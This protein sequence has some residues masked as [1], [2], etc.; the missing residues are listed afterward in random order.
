M[1]VANLGLAK[2]IALEFRRRGVELDDLIAE[3]TVGLIEAVDRFDGA[4]GVG[5]GV[6]ARVWIRA[7]CTRAVRAAHRPDVGGTDLDLDAFPAPE[8]AADPI[9]ETV[10]SAVEQLPADERVVTILAFGLHGADPVGRRR[11][12]AGLGVGDKAVRHRQA[13]SRRRLKRLLA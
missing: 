2:T 11:I 7:Y 6:F 1:I 4:L 9:A 13:R 10:W 5:F 12:A 3:A 8:A